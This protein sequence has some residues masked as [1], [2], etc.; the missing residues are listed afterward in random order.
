MTRKNISRLEYEKR[1]NRVIDYIVAH[2]SEELS[3]E[4]LSQ[5]AAF[6]SFHFHRIFKSITNENI[7]EF[8]TRIRL[9][10]A[11]NMLMSRPAGDI[12][13]IALDNGFSSASSFARAFKDHFGMSAT[14]WREGGGKDWQLR[15]ENSNLRQQESKARKDGKTDFDD[16]SSM[17]HSQE[18]NMNVKIKTLPNYHIAYMRNIGPYGPE[19]GKLW[20][21][22]NQWAE[23]YSLRTN[24]RISLGISYDNPNVTAP[25]K[26]RY[27]AALVVPKNFKAD[28]Q[29]NLADVPGGKYAVLKYAGTPMDIGKAYSDLFGVWLP[30]SGFQPDNRPIFEL[31]VG[32]AEI[33]PRKGTLK[34]EICMPIRPL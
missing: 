21:K 15:K 9:E 31:Y 22:L 26:C 5:V 34:C 7:S 18:E 33:D 14:E 4:L 20:N 30:N 28:T 17:S 16:T 1:V 13:G 2:R 3:L 10:W 6:S 8:V 11:A 32:E 19:V 25:E 24:D 27:D 12:M 29:V 23:L